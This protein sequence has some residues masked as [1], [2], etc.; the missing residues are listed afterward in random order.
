M[1]KLSNVKAKKGSVRKKFKKA[2]GISS[3][4]GKTSGRGHRGQKCRSG[5]SK[6]PGFE[7]GQTPIFRRLPKRQLNTR[8]NRKEYSTINLADLQKLADKG[9]TEVDVITLIETGALSKLAKYG[10]KVLG[11]GKLSA[12]LNVTAD[13]FSAAAKAAIEAAGGTATIDN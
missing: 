9:I 12:K 11:N 6:K 2:R 7:G 5:Y 13:K 10:L 3:G 1:S 8:V 4:A